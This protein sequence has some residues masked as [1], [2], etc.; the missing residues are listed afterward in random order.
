M[1][2]SKRYEIYLDSSQPGEKFKTN[3]LEDA[4]S[5]A[6]EKAKNTKRNHKIYDNKKKEVAGVVKPN[7]KIERTADS[8][9]GRSQNDAVNTGVIEIDKTALKEMVREAVFA[10][11]DGFV[12]KPVT[13]ITKSQLAEAV[14]KATKK[15]IL[16]EASE[17]NGAKGIGAYASS[18]DKFVADSI[19]SIDK[20]VE[21]G[22]KLMAENPTHDYAIQER[23]HL[24][25]ARIGILKGLKANLVKI[26]EELFRK[27]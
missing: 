25:Q 19:D 5:I 17:E 10:K 3:D 9:L 13:K 23:N 14:S 8:V 27:V 24:V 7:G 2:G 4:V 6:I 1:E 11:L 21:D 18:I 22:E 15:F 20:L 26:T 16:L 12:N